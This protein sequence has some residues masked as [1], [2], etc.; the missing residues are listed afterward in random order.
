VK[1]VFQPVG[2][3]LSVSVHA[4]SRHDSI[5]DLYA[6]VGMQKAMWLNTVTRCIV[7]DSGLSYLV[8]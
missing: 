2:N 4:G 5:T 7:A 6:A 1:R 3:L 8:C